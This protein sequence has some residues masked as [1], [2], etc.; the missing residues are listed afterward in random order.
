MSNAF[1][2][3]ITKKALLSIIST[4]KNV[5]SWILPLPPPSFLARSP[6]LRFKGDLGQKTLNGMRAHAQICIGM[7]ALCTS[8]ILPPRCSM[9]ARQ[10]WGLGFGG[11]NHR[12]GARF[13]RSRPTVT[14]PNPKPQSWLAAGTIIT[15]CRI[16][17]LTLNLNR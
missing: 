2:L 5:T 12:S 9:L 15:L 6:G 13:A 17:T 3:P 10:D 7:A 11:G 4:E 14:G 8:W 16:L 1:V